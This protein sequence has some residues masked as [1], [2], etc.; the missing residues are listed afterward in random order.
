MRDELITIAKGYM[1]ASV[2]STFFSYFVMG[3]EG[4]SV[5]AGIHFVVMIIMYYCICGEEL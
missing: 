3:W 1:I 2:V 4:V 5:V